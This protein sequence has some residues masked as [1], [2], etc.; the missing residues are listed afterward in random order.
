MVLHLCSIVDRRACGLAVS[1]TRSYWKCKIS[2]RIWVWSVK[3][4]CEETLHKMSGDIGIG[5][6]RLFYNWSVLLLEMPSLL[7]CLYVKGSLA[8][9]HNG[10]LV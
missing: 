6:V 3:Y 10:N 5:H 2:Q 4:F 9:A 1:D 7:F 8:L